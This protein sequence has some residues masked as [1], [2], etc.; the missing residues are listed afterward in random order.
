MPFSF[1]LHDTLRPVLAAGLGLWPRRRPSI[2]LLKKIKVIGHRGGLFPGLSE[3]TLPAFAQALQD[4][5]HGIESDVRLT[6]DGQVVLCHDP[7]LWRV[8]GRRINILDY[9]LVQLQAAVPDLPTLSQLLDLVQKSMVQASIFIELKESASP[10]ADALLAEKVQ[11]LIEN[12]LLAPQITLFSFWPHL[13][14]PLALPRRS[15]KL[16]AIAAA[17][18]WKSLQFVES[19]GFDGI[20]GFYLAITG[21]I[22]EKAKALGLE[23]GTGFID[24]ERLAAREINRGVDYLMTDFP[25]RIKQWVDVA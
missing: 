25:R 23:I 15:W 2:E 10:R 8:F 16:M 12:H 5:A 4:G 11:Q 7:D 17:Q 1:L 14:L 22:I 6:A 9:T 20:F 18:P 24:S 13:L 19:H 21:R 3:N